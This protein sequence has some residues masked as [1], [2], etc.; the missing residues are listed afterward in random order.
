MSNYKEELL[1]DHLD[2]S[3]LGKGSPE[4]DRLI[5]DDA[6][7][8]VTWRYLNLAVD[9]VRNAAL[10]ERVM[11]VRK[12]WMAKQA[13]GQ[14]TGTATP[15]ARVFTI[16]RNVMRVA[17]CI[18][19][20]T[21]GAAVYKYTTISATGIYQEYYS[22][23][24][25]TTSRGAGVA[26]PIDEA[27]NNKNWVKVLALFNTTKDKSIRSF[28][29]AGMADLE[30][31][32]YQAATAQFQQ[33]MAENMRSGGDY[34]QDEAEYYMAMSLLAENRADQAL[35]LLEKIR[36]DP[37]HLYHQKVAAMSFT[38]LRIASFKSHK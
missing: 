31:K 37:D 38:D 8:A 1:I 9:T 24:E 25:L 21:G 5:A 6:D 13:A 7:I 30:L 28:F 22:S 19:L 18:L 33:V 17:A 20:L 14:T 29:F 11:V 4:V 12:E 2:D 27:Y 32:N 26:D 35:P 16:Y 15:K 34:F 23:Y 10:H 36:T 3:L